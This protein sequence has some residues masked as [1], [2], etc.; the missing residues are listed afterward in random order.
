MNK[1]LWIKDVLLS[2][3]AVIIASVILV[4]GY[5]SLKNGSTFPGITPYIIALLETIVFTFRQRYKLI[6]DFLEIVFG[7][8]LCLVNID[9]VIHVYELGYSIVSQQLGGLYV[10]VRGFDNISKIINKYPQSKISVEI[11]NRQ[12]NIRIWWLKIFGSF[13]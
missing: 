3:V 9:K 13:D 7:I 4:E 8:F 12:K 2:V 6:Y 10:I 5:V 11:Q 1:Y